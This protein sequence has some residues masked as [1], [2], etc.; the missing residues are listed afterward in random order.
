MV[1]LS[2]PKES[3]TK[4]YALKLSLIVILYVFDNGLNIFTES[5]DESP[6]QIGVAS[7]IS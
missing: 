7:E 5:A 1:V 4:L 2:K 3:T 6:T